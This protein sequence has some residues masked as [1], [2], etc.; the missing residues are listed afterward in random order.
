MFGWPKHLKEN[1]NEEKKK[2]KKMIS[3]KI[4]NDRNGLC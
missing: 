4:L 2:Q 3:I 1:Q